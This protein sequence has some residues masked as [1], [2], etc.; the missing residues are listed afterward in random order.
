M[1]GCELKNVK[2]ATD[3]VPNIIAEIKT[4]FYHENFS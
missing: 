4:V 3:S 2:I 1:L